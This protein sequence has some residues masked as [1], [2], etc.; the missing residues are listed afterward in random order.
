MSYLIRLLEPADQGIL[1]EMLYLALYVPPEA[2]PLGRDIVYKPELAKYVQAWGKAGD[3][4]LVAS[5]SDNQ[6]AIGAAWLRL[7]QQDN[8]GYGYINDAT[9]ELAIAVLPD[10]RN[11]GI[12]TALLTQL[13]HQAKERYAAISLSV[14]LYNPALRLY[15]RFG[16]EA[17]ERSDDALTM[18]KLLGQA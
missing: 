1:W 10:Y 18:K 11:Q 4:G 17:V 13:C 9:P 16:F 3:L 7:F 5:L 15:R 2:P 14:A 12:G 6:M 8:P